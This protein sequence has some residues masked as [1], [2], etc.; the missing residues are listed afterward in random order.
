MFF[1]GGEALFFAEG[2][3]LFPEGGLLFPEGGELLFGGGAATAR[4]HSG[5]LFAA[6][7]DRARGSKIADDWIVPFMVR[8][9]ERTT[10][11]KNLVR[12]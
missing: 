8:F 9:T 6:T 4:A 11:G 2:E 1:A 5:L 7:R 12:K 3:A 10:R